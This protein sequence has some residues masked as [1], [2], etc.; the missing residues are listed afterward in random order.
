MRHIYAFERQE[1]HLLVDAVGVACEAAARADDAVAGDDDGY[2]I[3]RD[4]AADR[5]GGLFHANAAGYCAVGHRFAVGNREQDVPDF[6]AKRRGLRC[7]RRQKVGILAAEVEFEPAARL[8][9]YGEAFLLV[10]L[11]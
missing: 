11:F 8:L 6:F 4:G 2:G 9:E 7:E 10:F 5:V 1:L 3:V